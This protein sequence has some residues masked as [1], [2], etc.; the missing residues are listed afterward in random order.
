MLV[1]VVSSRIVVMVNVTAE[2]FAPSRLSGLAVLIPLPGSGPIVGPRGVV[3][4]LVI[5]VGAVLLLVV[6]PPV[7]LK[8]V[9]NLLELV[10]VTILPRVAPLVDSIA[11][12][13][14]PVKLAFPSVIAIAIPLV[15]VNG[16]VG[17][18]GPLVRCAPTVRSAYE[19]LTPS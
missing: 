14:D 3:S 16:P 2:V 8:V 6:I 15:V 13:K 17:L 18:I 11:T 4:V 5:R 9:L 12:L 1:L 19:A 10:L 7:V